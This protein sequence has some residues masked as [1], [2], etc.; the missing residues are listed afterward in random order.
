[1]E[2]II[3]TLKAVFVEIL[4]MNIKTARQLNASLA[5]KFRDVI[6]I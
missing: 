6:L 4:Y 1:M 2:I 3:E 5:V